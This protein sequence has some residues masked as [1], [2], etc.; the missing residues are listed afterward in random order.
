MLAGW[1]LGAQD[2]SP[3]SAL[4]A[5]LTLKDCF[6]LTLRHNQDLLASRLGAEAARAR[7][8]AAKGPFDPVLFAEDRWT[9]ADDPQDTLPKDAT[10]TREGAFSSG[11]RKRFATGT[12]VEL[13]GTASYTDTEDPTTAFDP[14]VA[15]GTGVTLYQDLLRDLGL[16]VNRHEILDARDA[17]R[18]EQ[19]AVRDLVSRTLYDVE[20]VYWSLFFAEADL[21]VREEQLGRANRLV[22][23]AEAQ[24][25]VGES[26]PIE[27]TR[28]R[29]SAASQQVSIVSARSRI[30]LLR[31]RLLR[32]LGVFQAGQPGAA[33]EV[34]DVPPSSGTVPV[35]G[36]SLQAARTHRPDCQRAEIVRAR[37]ERRE[38]YTWN[39]RLPT[40]QVFGGL[41]LSGLDDSWHESRSDLG[42][43]D[44]Q[45]WHAGVRLEVPLGNRAAEGSY[46]A[47]CMER[48]RAVA[49]GQAVYDQ[50][51]REVADA[52][53]EVTTAGAQVEASRQSRELAATLLQA[54]EKSF[55]IGRSSSLDVLDAQ[56]SLA[57]AEREELRARVTFATALSYLYVVRGDFLEAKGLPPEARLEHE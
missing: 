10:E 1:A 41:A 51:M 14:S 36:E 29:S 26:A 38:D 4:P 11:L 49:Q 33:F 31:N 8:L 23:V 45:T 55:R 44:Y 21:K 3:V 24:V 52:F 5:R 37:A 2:S 57:S 48:R 9:Q 20:A 12:S 42:G 13:A 18:L 7:I 19:E 54:E 30:N 34:A 6:D 47:A 43:T 25:R 15:T 17:W 56:E 39:Q 53:E 22:A 32:Q 35:L 50:A 16:D 27:I 46:R 40:L 28:A